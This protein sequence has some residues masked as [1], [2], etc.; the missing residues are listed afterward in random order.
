MTPT[1]KSDNTCKATKMFDLCALSLDILL[2]V[3][4][5]RSKQTMKVHVMIWTTIKIINTT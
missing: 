1:M 3:T 5:D 2:Q 4:P